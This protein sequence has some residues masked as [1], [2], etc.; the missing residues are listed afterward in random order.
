MKLITLL[1]LIFTTSAFAYNPMGG[2][3]YNQKT[4]EKIVLTCEDAEV[5][6]NCTQAYFTL[7][8]T[9]GKDTKLHQEFAIPMDDSS[10]SHYERY[11]MFYILR[12]RTIEATAY[13]LTAVFN[14]M[15][16]SKNFREAVKIMFS[17]KEADFNTG[18]KVSNKNFKAMVESIK[19]IY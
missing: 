6:K 11:Y 19:A 9:A 7:V 15:K 3:F 12:D 18:I 1:S 16:I 10:D 14:S 4:K 5:A 2:F 13:G 17:K 8:D